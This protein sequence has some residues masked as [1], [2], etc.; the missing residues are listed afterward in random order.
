MSR[1]AWLI[2]EDG[3]EFEGN[4]FGYE[5]ESLGEIVINTSMGGYQELLTS[6]SSIKQIIA[7]TYPTIGNYGANTTD[8]E[9]DKVYAHGIIVSEY[10]KTYSNFRAEKSLQDYLKEEKIAAIEDID[11]R[12]LAK[13]IR[14]KGTM[15]G[16][17]FFDKKDSIHKLKS[18][19]LEDDLAAEVSCKE[20]YIFGERKDSSPEI[21]LFDFGVNKSLLM[22]L[23]SLQFN[24]TV[25]PSNTPLHEA[26]KDGAKGI[27]LSNGPGN[28]ESIPYAIT[29]AKDIMSEK[30]PCFGIDLGHQILSLGFGGKTYKLKFGHRGAN[31]PVKN[32]ETGKV[33]IT[34][35]NHGFA[36][37]ADSLKSNGDV[38]ITHINLNDNTVEGLRHKILPIFSVQYLPEPDNWQNMSHYLFDK[39]KKMAAG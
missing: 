17:I 15:M 10:S 12:K 18:I 22:F 9:S 31:H 8:V 23:D 20:R 39:F 11:T 26:I 32:I 13:L 19:R 30:I 27:I 38:D 37:D 3:A 14:E 16:G 29:L 7:L 2:L 34:C 25:Y 4:S 21:A 5:T 35:Q 24:V 33:E 36:V 28:P 1:K 6:P